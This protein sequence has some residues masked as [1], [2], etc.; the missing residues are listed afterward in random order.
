MCVLLKVNKN[1]SYR[2]TIQK[3]TPLAY[4]LVLGGP[5]GRSKIMLPNFFF[6]PA[7]PKSLVKLVE[8]L[9]IGLSFGF[10]SKLVLNGVGFRAWDFNNF[11]LLDLGFNNFFFYVKPVG[12]KILV[13]KNFLLIFGVVKQSVST[14]ALQLKSLKKPDSYKGKGIRVFGEEILLKKKKKDGK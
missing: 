9:H 11:I 4:F 7:A 3:V 6:S 1:N 13:K 5:L 10:F 2:L 12:M 14:V 8:N